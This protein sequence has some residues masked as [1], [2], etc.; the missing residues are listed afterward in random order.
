HHPVGD[1]A[2]D[3]IRLSFNPQLRIEF[4]GATATSDAGLLLPRELDERPRRKCADRATPHRSPH[5]TQCPIPS[6]RS[7]SP[8]HPQPA[9]RIPDTNDAEAEAG[10]QINQP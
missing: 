1:A 8:V 9:G 2:S 7:V 4:R 5:W 3:P 6:P 10:M